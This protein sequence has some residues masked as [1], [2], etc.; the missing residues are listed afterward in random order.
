MK[1][2]IL[3][4]LLL[5]SIYSQAQTTSNYTIID[6]NNAFMRN[7]DNG[8]LAMEG[9][10]GGAGYKIDKNAPQGIIF[11]SAFWFAG[12]GDS[13]KIRMCAQTYQN[14]KDQSP[15][16]YSSTGDYNAPE[17]TSSYGFS[18][19]VMSQAIIDDHIANY[20]TPGYTINPSL[21]YWPAHGDT[22]IG[23]S[24]NLAPYV[25]V[26]NNGVYDPL[27]GDY[28]KI[29]GCMATY[30]ITNDDAEPH[31]ASGG[32]KLGIEIHYMIYQMSENSLYDDVTFIDL[33]VYKRS[34][35]LLK[36]FTVTYFVD[37]DIGTT[38]DDYTGSNPER[39][40]MFFYNSTN[41]DQASNKPNYGINPPAF[42]VVCLNDTMNSS[43]H[44]T[45]GFQDPQTPSDFWQYMN[46]RDKFGSPW[47]DQDGNPTPYPLPG[48]PN[49]PNEY[50]AYNTPVAP[51]D[52]RG[53]MSIKTGTVAPGDVFKRTFAIVPSTSGND[54]LDQVSKLFTRVDKIQDDYD[55]FMLNDCDVTLNVTDQEV[56]SSLL[57][58]PNP[59]RSIINVKGLGNGKNEVQIV[60]VLGQVHIKT[61]LNSTSD[62]IDVQHLP[63]GIYL[64][65]IKGEDGK[66]STLKFIKE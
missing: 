37:G 17:Y 6:F 18:Y 32:G 51:D 3:I 42:G 39:N 55:S 35:E 58:Y 16:P 64:L 11:S 21:E 5:M 44:Y 14:E 50:S 57:L 30:I 33:T 53:I 29:K 62:S 49:D 13:A 4:P 46:G 20:N 10:L 26:N 56:S 19:W 47:T 28:P 59:S 40:M 63:K 31:T 24:Y 43:G 34:N 52:Y 25:D 7:S 65:R 38:F 8:F 15:G 22:T 48:D 12:I 61:I 41:D 54:H 9:A 27:N 2:L 23:V 60:D 66:S 45:I 36:D 1:K